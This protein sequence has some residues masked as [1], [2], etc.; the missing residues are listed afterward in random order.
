M[1]SK[2]VVIFW[3]A[4]GASILF[5]GALWSTVDRLGSS[6]DRTIDIMIVVLAS[7]GLVV[8]LFVS[9]RI[10]VVMGRMRRGA[11]REPS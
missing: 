6:G 2:P 8:S 7:T 4:T 11:H 3:G 1:R 9:G 5:L 10:A